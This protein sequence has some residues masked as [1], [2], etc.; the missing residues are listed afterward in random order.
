[1]AIIVLIGVGIIM[2]LSLFYHL[3]FLRNP[4][5][6]SPKGNVI[7]SPAMGKISRIIEIKNGAPVTIPK[8]FIGKINTLTNDTIQKGYLITII[9]TPLDV[10]YQRMPIDGKIISV[11]YDKGTFL[12]AVQGD[13][14]KA[15]LE[16]EHNEILI[17]N[18]KIGKI[19]VIQI[20]GFVARR[21]VCSARKN[22]KLKIGATL[23][24]IR[25]G[26]QVALIIP[27]LPLHVKEGQ[28]V[29]DGETIIATY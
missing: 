14:F 2:A 24:L 3:W 28:K 26:S 13:T 25:L 5:R 21:I 16:N 8:G 29:T 4:A 19:K 27:K 23:G 10:H 11:K 12:N 17:E 18:K 15:T 22:Q 9:M 20:A 6:I 1:M 7:V